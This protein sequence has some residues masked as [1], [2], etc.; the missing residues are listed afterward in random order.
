M[1]GEKG[2]MNLLFFSMEQYCCMSRLVELTKKRLF[3]HVAGHLMGVILACGR[4]FDVIGRCHFGMWHD[5]HLFLICHALLL[6]S[7]L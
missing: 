4:L 2:R 6:V 1:E 5:D 7:P 3:G